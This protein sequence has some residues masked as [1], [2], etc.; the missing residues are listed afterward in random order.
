M[1]RTPPP[2]K[3]TSKNTERPPPPPPSNPL[4]TPRLA[5]PDP[6]ARRRLAD[7][8]GNQPPLTASRTRGGAEAAPPGEGPPTEE[9]LTPE[10][11]AAQEQEAAAEAAAS[12]Q[13][14]GAAEKEP[15]VKTPKNSTT[16]DSDGDDDSPGKPD[17]PPF[18][19][20]NIFG[21]MSETVNIPTSDHDGDGVAVEVAEGRTEE[22]QGI[23]SRRS[24]QARNLKRTSEDADKIY[25]KD[26]ASTEDLLM[27]RD[28]LQTM[29]MCVANIEKYNAALLMLISQSR[30]N[31]KKFIDWSF[32]AVNSAIQQSRNIQVLL[33]Q[34][35]IEFRDESKGAL[36]KV[37]LEKAD[38]T[39][40]AT[41]IVE[42]GGGGG[43]KSDPTKMPKRD[44]LAT[45]KFTGKPGADFRDFKENC[46]EIFGS[47]T[48]SYVTKFWCLK[49]VLPEKLQ[50]Q[51][52][53][54]KKTQ[55]GYSN[56]WT[57][58]EE[59]YGSNTA[60][61]LEYLQKLKTLPEVTEQNG[62]ISLSKLELHYTQVKA[63]I[64]NLESVGMTGKRHHGSWCGEMSAKLPMSMS[65][66]WAKKYAEL[67]KD[68][69]KDPVAEYMTF[70]KA[71]LDGLRT[72]V[73]NYK[74]TTQTTTKSN[75]K[76]KASTEQTYY[77]SERGRGQN[78]GGSRGRG[79][80]GRG[81]HSQGPSR[82]ASGPT[83]SDNTPFVSKQPDFC[84]L[85]SKG[86]EK[87]KHHPH[88]CTK[89]DRAKGYV[90]VYEANACTACGNIGHHQDTCRTK[91]ECPEEGCTY[92]HMK[93]LHQC[94]FMKHADWAAGK[95]K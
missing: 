5:R 9:G 94:T 34:E 92:F 26:D 1:Q 76:P 3:K 15:G 10:Q 4:G 18:R 25:E 47:N 20:D 46:I 93:P 50:T 79:G 86:Q 39:L 80:R 73:T 78:R 89:P 42:E 49:Q 31:N 55:E 32:R 12:A 87:Q 74:V 90:R 19:R 13:A 48:Y 17:P 71:E 24:Y 43:S 58:L 70:I 77:T 82:S 22:F 44:V 57:D 27:L 33:K 81:G 37:K 85:C 21:A 29:N 30:T 54:Y 59:S 56:F 61:K 62:K 35:D 8:A 91:K 53:G 14:A 69:A 84:Y 66:V 68:D 67:E 23:L 16:H 41:T 38:N 83:S 40:D 60:I 65:R 95:S 72:V 45:I 2:T 88:H 63:C 11:Q 6:L 51:L 7:T 28:L 64:R 75:S 52:A 36:P